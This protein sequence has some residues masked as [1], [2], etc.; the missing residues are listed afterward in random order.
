ML[1]KSSGH[2]LSLK[3][4]IFV[5]EM[6]HGYMYAI[7]TYN[8]GELFS[9][10]LEPKSIAAHFMLEKRFTASFVLKMSHGYMYA[11]RTYNQ[12]LFSNIS[13]LV[14]TESFTAMVILRYTYI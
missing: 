6:S 10:I 13:C 11:I 1:E 8:H 5:L 7:R 3:Y 14:R 2:L 4:N 12:W 9:N